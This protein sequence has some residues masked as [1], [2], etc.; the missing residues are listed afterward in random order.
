MYNRRRNIIPVLVIALL[1]ACVCQTSPSYAQENTTITDVYLYKYMGTNTHYGKIKN[2]SGYAICCDPGKAYPEKKTNGIATLITAKSSESK[3][4]GAKIVYYYLYKQSDV[5]Q[6]SSSHMVAARLALSRA[7][8]GENY[9]LRSWY[10]DKFPQVVKEAD[11]IYWDAKD[12]KWPDD[13]RFEAFL[14]E[15]NNS[16]QQRLFAYRIKSSGKCRIV[17]SSSDNAATMM[18]QEYSFEGI[19]YGIYTTSSCTVKARTIKGETAVAQL[20]SSGTSK[21]I[22]LLSGT[23]YVKETRSNDDYCLNTTAYKMVVQTGK[24]VSVN[25]KDNPR[26]AHVKFTK[27]V[28]DNTLNVSD[29]AGLKFN[30]YSKWNKAANYSAI[31]DKNGV[32]DFGDVPFGKYRLIEDTE[33]IARKNDALAERESE[34]EFDGSGI[35]RDVEVTEDTNNLITGEYAANKTKKSKRKYEVT[36]VKKI[37]NRNGD[38]IVLTNAAGEDARSGNKFK[39]SGSTVSGK[40]I[41]IITATDK[42]G[43]AVFN[44]ENG[45]N[46]AGEYELREVD[47]DKRVYIE[48]SKVEYITLKD[49]K[50]DKRKTVL[51]ENIAKTASIEIVKKSDDGITEGVV[52]SLNGTDVLGNT[53]NEIVKP[54]EIGENGNG[55]LSFENCLPGIYTVEE[56]GWNASKYYSPDGLKPKKTIELA[57]NNETLE[58]E[59]VPYSIHLKKF[60]KR[61]NGTETNNPVE[62]AVYSLYRVEDGCFLDNYTTDENG[63]INICGGLEKTEYK[64]IET[65]TPNGYLSSTEELLIHE[66]DFIKSVCN[67]VD[68]NQREYGEIHICKISDN[69]QPVDGAEFVLCSDSECKHVIATGRSVYEKFGNVVNDNDGKDGF[70]NLDWGT[71][72]FKETKAP[73]GYE[74]D[75]TIYKAVVSGKDD[76]LTYRGYEIINQR[77]KGCVEFTKWNTDRSLPLNGAV[78]SLFLSDGTL[79]KDNLTTGAD[80]DGDGATDGAGCIAVKNL[81]WGSYYFKE[82]MAPDN[83]SLSP[84]LIR[85]TVNY[86]GTDVVQKLQAV[87]ENEETAVVATKKVLAEDLWWDNGNPTFV[88][89]L[90]GT[91]DEGKKV[92]LNQPVTFTQ[93]YV[94]QHTDENGYVSRSVTFSPLIAGK[95]ELTENEVLTY[96]FESVE[97][98]VNGVNASTG[99]GKVVF[100]H[101]DVNHKGAAT[102]IN[103]KDDWSYYSDQKSLTN[104]VKKSRACTGIAVDY[105][106]PVEYEGNC[107]FDRNDLYVWALYDDGSEKRLGNNDYD[108]ADEDGNEFVKTQRQAGSYQIAVNYD[109]GIGIRT[110]FFQLKVAPMEVKYVSFDTNGGTTLEKLRVWKN[111]SLNATNP[112]DNQVHSKKEG[113]ILGNEDNPKTGWYIDENCS[114]L[115]DWDMPITSDITLYAKWVRKDIEPPKNLQIISSNEMDSS[116]NVRLV[117]TDNIAISS[118]YF[119]KNNTPDESDYKK[120]GDI[121]ELDVVST[122]SESGKYYLVVRDAENNKAVINQSFFET[123]LNVNGGTGTHASVLTQDGKSF[124]IPEATKPGEELIG[125]ADRRNADEN[126]KWFDTG[127]TLF[128][129]Q[130]SEIFAQYYDVNTLEEDY[131][132]YVESSDL[133]YQE[134]T[135]PKKA[136]SSFSSATNNVEAANNTITMAGFNSDP[137]VNYSGFYNSSKIY[138]YLKNYVAADYPA[139]ATKAYCLCCKPRT[140]QLGNG[141]IDIRIRNLQN[142]QEACLKYTDFSIYEAVNTYNLS[143][144]SRDESRIDIDNDNAKSIAVA[145]WWNENNGGNVSRV[146]TCGVVP[147]GIIDLRNYYSSAAKFKTHVAFLCVENKTTGNREIADYSQAYSTIAARRYHAL[148]TL[149]EQRY[150]YFKKSNLV[151]KKYT[152]GASFTT[153]GTT[154]AR[155]ETNV[156]FKT[157]DARN[158][159]LANCGRQ[160][161]NGDA[162]SGC[163]YNLAREQRLSAY[164]TQNASIIYSANGIYNTSKK[165]WHNS[166][167]CKVTS[168]ALCLEY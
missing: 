24:T 6:K 140:A 152:S 142:T 64:L 34:Y 122:V 146:I 59:N 157:G 72:Y 36:V 90:I 124:K 70:C 139:V 88:F 155:F 101:I 164:N 31:A 100:E 93:E 13:V 30:L 55:Y 67:V 63:E 154:V 20:N 4:I 138:L 163:S 121:T 108:L 89:H 143:A 136:I 147:N 1:F 159:V 11:A 118:Y 107:E 162:G 81:D 161:S 42:S 131:S 69:Q 39:L 12:K 2:M 40:T 22:E 3:K 71:Y 78:Y 134:V 54:T 151:V 18:N 47:T 33:S 65:I 10:E 80:N 83:Y 111:D 166:N 119:G 150:N 105:K 58:F 7:M 38:E 160:V 73:R 46:E 79:V 9:T 86:L 128:P 148:K 99:E 19:E 17:K 110:A 84:E 53:V 14:F 127:S 56:I 102:F 74:L 29:V 109:S 28:A 57:G 165:T 16:N 133:S 21:E 76:N 44:E 27:T 85:F 60:E 66:N 98:V 156:T 137:H 132:T 5:Y 95:Y 125:W 37:L 45:L 153:S 113:Y 106:G 50:V 35:D 32:V 91:T 167:K 168:H 41:E 145:G 129:T 92:S 94:T 51:F 82:K 77:K 103:K 149:D 25:V 141:T 115:F 23:Y 130:D 49:N 61:E 96:A 104:I 68:Y 135:L 26:K 43:K 126:S 114:K 52:F 117:A 48:N 112:N 15:T 123:I 116:Q 8:H 97:N 62:G 87:D 144:S 120:T 158:R 75:E